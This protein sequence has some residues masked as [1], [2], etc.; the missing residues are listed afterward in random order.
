MLP[1]PVI[2]LIPSEQFPKDS[3]AFLVL[4][5]DYFA[6]KLPGKV[7]VR[8]SQGKSVLLD[9]FTFRIQLL[10]TLWKTSNQTLETM[11]NNLLKF[12]YD[13]GKEFTSSIQEALKS[14]LV[15]NSKFKKRF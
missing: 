2:G 7:H 12:H 15:K 1:T 13:T 14:V 5:L 11:K 3:L 4:Y 10:D 9:T 6:K 8:D